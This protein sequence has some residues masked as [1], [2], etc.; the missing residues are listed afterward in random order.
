[1]LSSSRFK[2]ELWARQRADFTVWRQNRSIPDA[3]GLQFT[4][5]RAGLRASRI[6]FMARIAPRHDEDLTD[7][8]AHNLEYLLDEFK[9]LDLLIN[10]AL[11]KGGQVL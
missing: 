2:I 1:V 11:L 7:G 9:R 6:F 4:L 10:L 3:F 5:A 8:Y